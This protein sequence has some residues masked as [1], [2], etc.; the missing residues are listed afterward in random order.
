MYL[1]IEGLF[2]YLFF[3]SHFSQIGFF[4]CVKKKKLLCTLSFFFL[5]NGSF[6][7]FVQAKQSKA[8]Q[9]HLAQILSNNI[10][11]YSFGLSG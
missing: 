7:F 10:A 3:S 6:Q 4:L 9:S 5:K 8:K 1:K 2:T 11:I